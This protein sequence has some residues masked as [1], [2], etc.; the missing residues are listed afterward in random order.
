MQAEPIQASR[1]DLRIF[2][3]IMA[4]M[5]SLFFGLLLPW[6]WSAAAYP[7][8]PWI[9]SGVFLALGMAL[10]DLLLPVYKGWMKFAHVLGWINTRLILSLVFYVVIFP[11]GLIFKLIGKDPMAR[12]FDPKLSTYRVERERQPLKQSLEKPF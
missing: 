11:I 2:S 1:K 12:R 5:I 10:P 6:I 3:L 9:V 4:I 7:V 8:W